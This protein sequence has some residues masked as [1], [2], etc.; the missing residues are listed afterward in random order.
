MAV[1][2]RSHGLPGQAAPP[3]PIL[4]DSPATAPGSGAVP[5]LFPPRARPAKPGQ[6]ESAGSRPARMVVAGPALWERG[7]VEAKIW[8]WG[9]GSC[10]SVYTAGKGAS[11]PVKWEVFGWRCA[12][13]PLRFAGVAVADGRLASWSPQVAPL[14]S[15]RGSSS[16]PLPRFCL[17]QSNSALIPPPSS[18]QGPCRSHQMKHHSLDSRCPL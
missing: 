15:L 17:S 11:V 2:E 16:N 8:A 12:V 14:W 10:G 13:W 5:G 3:G 7:R 1:H 6:A 18:G 9:R 4:G